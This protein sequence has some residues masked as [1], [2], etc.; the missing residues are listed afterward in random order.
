M[1]QQK[2]LLLLL[3][4]LFIIRLFVLFHYII[5]TQK[6]KI[7]Y[8]HAKQKQFSIYLAIHYKCA[9]RNGVHLHRHY[10]IHSFCTFVLL[11]T[12]LRS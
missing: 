5:F 3:C 8:N 7:I 11:R 12:Y 10:S 4:C 6:E 2:L 1:S 9:P